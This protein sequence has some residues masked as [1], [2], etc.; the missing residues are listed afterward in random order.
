[1][2]SAIFLILLIGAVIG[3]ANGLLVSKVKINAFIAT[4]GV[5]SVVTG[6]ARGANEGALVN[7]LPSSFLNLVTG[8]IGPIPRIVLISLVI[9]GLLWYLLERTVLGRQMYAIGENPEAA[10][11]AGV[12][13]DLLRIVGFVLVGIL[14]ALAGLMLTA[15]AGS[16]SPDAAIGLLLPAY[17]AAFLGASTLKPGEFHIAGTVIGVLLASVTVTGLTMLNVAFWVS[18]IVQG[19]ILLLAVGLARRH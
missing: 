13:V 19:G 18:Y 16:S 12:R 3:L 7:I 6:L 4:L 8:D 10:M 5:G 15:R 9:A 14:A 2:D 17:A 1:V 11:L